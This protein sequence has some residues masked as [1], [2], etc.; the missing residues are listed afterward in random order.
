MIQTE[1]FNSDGEEE[2]WINQGRS[3]ARDGW[4]PNSSGGIAYQRHAGYHAE[5]IVFSEWGAEEWARWPDTYDNYKKWH[6]L[7][8]ETW[9]EEMNTLQVRHFHSIL[10]KTFQGF[11]C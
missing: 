1:S 5:S 4:I 6:A 10:S 3:S 9:D 8:A 11:R 7:R 2:F